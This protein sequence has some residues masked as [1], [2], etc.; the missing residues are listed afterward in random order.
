MVP[1]CLVG[2]VPLCLVGGKREERNKEEENAPTLLLCSN[3]QAAKELFFLLV[4]FSPFNFIIQ[5]KVQRKTKQ[6]SF[7]VLKDY[8]AENQIEK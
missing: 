5:S 4:I 2:M 3:W 8:N 6:T 7:A 1:L